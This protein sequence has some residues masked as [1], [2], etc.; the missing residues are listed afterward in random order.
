MST[1]PQFV[2]RTSDLVHAFRRTHTSASAADIVAHPPALARIHRA[3]THTTLCRRACLG[4]GMPHTE[5]RY[6][7][8]KLRR[9]GYAFVKLRAPSPNTK[10]ARLQCAL[11]RQTVHART[12]ECTSE[13]PTHTHR[14]LCAPNV[15]EIILC[16]YTLGTRTRQTCHTLHTHLVTHKHTRAHTSF[17]C[18]NQSY[19]KWMSASGRDVCS[20]ACRFDIFCNIDCRSPPRAGVCN[21]IQT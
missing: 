6:T 16:A 12:F 3:R 15:H 20:A 13:M 9:R 5:I 4:P 14:T 17:R 10:C 11:A 2:V 19:R 8:I 18:Y 7:H 21:Y 1:C